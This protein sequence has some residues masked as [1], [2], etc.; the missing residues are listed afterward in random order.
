MRVDP[1]SLAWTRH[2]RFF[3]GGNTAWLFGGEVRIANVLLDHPLCVEE[4]AVQRDRA[5]H[6]FGVGEWESVEAWQDHTL[7]PEIQIQR[8]LRLIDRLRFVRADRPSRDTLDMSFD[9]PAIEHRQTRYAVERRLHAA[10][11]GRLQRFHRV[12]H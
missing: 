7:E 9:P 5:A 12:V 8:V 2:Y 4:R 1:S 3:Q 10:R 6:H 11:P